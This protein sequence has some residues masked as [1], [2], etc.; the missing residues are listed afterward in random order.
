MATLGPAAAA[1]VVSTPDGDVIDEASVTLGR[2]TNNVAEYRGLLLGLE[3]AR[4]HGATEVEVVNDSELVAKQV[5]GEYKVKHPEMAAL[6]EQAMDALAGFE[7]W[8]IRSVPRAQNAAAD[9][10]VNRALDE[11][12]GAAPQ[13]GTEYA[14]Y[15][16][17][18]DLLQLQQPL[19]PGAHDE[20]LFIIVH[21]SY[22]LWFK[23]I[24]HE[25]AKAQEEL[26]AGR[27]QGAL[28]PLKRTVTIERLLL[29]HL[30]VLETMGP[31]GFLEFRDPLAPASGFQ[32]QQFRAIESESPKLYDAFAACRRPPGRRPAA[33]GARRPLSR[34][35]RRPAPRAAARGRRAAGRPRRAGRAVAPPPHADGRARDRQPARHGRLARRRVPARHA[36]QALLS[37][38]VGGESRAVTDAFVGRERERAALEAAAAR[39]RAGEGSIVLLAGEAGV[40]KSMLARTALAGCDLELYEGFG[41]QDGASAYGPIAEALR[42]IRHA[43][44]GEVPLREQL[45]VILPELGPPAQVVERATVFEAIRSMVAAAASQRPLALLLDDLQ[46]ADGATLNLLP[47]LARTLESEPVLLVGAYRS[48][49]V[50]RGPSDPAP[51][52]RAAP[53]S[54]AARDRR[55]A[56]RRGGH[57]VAARAGPG[58]PGRTLPARRHLRSH[59]RG[60]VLRH[61][62]GARAGRERAPAAA[63]R[64]GA[65]CT[66]GRT[67]RCRTA[68]ATRCCCGRP[69]C[70]TRR[71]RRSR[72]RPSPARA[73]TSSR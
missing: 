67:S 3:R 2:A 64:R 57:R 25:L 5:N 43:R 39:A 33:R 71:G 26:E 18:D 40:G 10:L 52:Q 37:R 49:D 66:P 24:L 51:A 32:S 36:G 29:D 54:P 30:D 46:W 41:V 58:R 17:I 21:Q 45:A 68:C 35:P 6:R 44:D 60:A 69:A 50:P 34:P 16:R 15:L 56:V 13:E 7:R 14:G 65:S 12:N 11:A 42:A 28:R 61:R 19:T 59:R 72:W 20:L 23:L 8:S 27:P 70:P 47:A 38:P 9:A 1:A 22:E 62:A 63:A 73:S 31:E 53:R 48:D 4:E 55:R